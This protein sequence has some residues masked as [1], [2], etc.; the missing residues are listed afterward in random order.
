[1]QAQI[2]AALSAARI[3]VVTPPTGI[4]KAALAAQLPTYI[5]GR[6]E[7][8]WRFGR[9]LQLTSFSY[10]LLCESGQDAGAVDTCAIDL[11]TE[12][13][14]ALFPE[15]DQVRVS[16]QP[17]MEVMRPGQSGEGDDGADLAALFAFKPGDEDEE[18]PDPQWRPITHGAGDEP[19]AR[20]ALGVEWLYRGIYDTRN[21]AILASLAGCAPPG[22]HQL[23]DL[24]LAGYVGA[25]IDGMS[26]CFHDALGLAAQAGAAGHGGVVFL[27]VAYDLVAS[28]QRR[29]TVLAAVE[30]HGDAVAGR[31]ACTLFGAPMRP[32]LD[33]IVPLLDDL[34]RCFRFV[35]WQITQMDVD[36]ERI[37]PGGMHSITL[38]TALATRLVAPSAAELTTIRRT[39]H[40]FRLRFG[41]T[42]VNSQ[43]MMDKVLDAKVD[44][45][46][47]AYVT[48]A[49]PIPYPPQRVEADALPLNAASP[50]AVNPPDNTDIVEL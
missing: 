17:L 19:V 43:S 36:L 34:K 22:G 8:V 21:Q 40:E 49:A 13:S 38:N 46:V 23:G 9:T 47:G 14:A 27:P 30:R 37:G 5:G 16:A 28:K 15:A 31:V 26:Q 44:Y 50:N 25:E 24:T 45:L 18:D 41:L 20:Q 2:A 11:C 6:L 29:D 10:L 35:D 48:P 32:T 12:L 39:A 3:L 33:V 1:M 7:A 4:D 42:G